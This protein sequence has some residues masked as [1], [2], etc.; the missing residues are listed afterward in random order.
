[1]TV[2]IG[3]L[4]RRHAHLAP[5]A[6]ALVEPATG[7]RL[8]YRELNAR[9]NCVANGLARDR[10]ER[11]RSC[12]P[13]TDER[14]GISSSRSTQSPRSVPS[15]CRSTG[16][17]SRTSWSS[18][19]LTPGAKRCWCTGPSLPWLRTSSTHAGRRRRS[20]TGSRQAVTVPRAAVDYD[21]WL[22]SAIGRRA[23]VGRLGAE[24]TCCSSCTRAVPPDHRRVSDAHP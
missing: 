10:C 15:T 18:S 20:C 22:G 23:R 6:E 3:D 1:M 11:G 7:R 16:A 9:A 2:N 14:R 13:P 17:S 12:R 5:S 19:S 24:A 8:T 4:L 21:D